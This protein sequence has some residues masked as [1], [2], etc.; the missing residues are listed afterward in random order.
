MD[1]A[2][3][4][5]GRARCDLLGAASNLWQTVGA[6]LLGSAHMLALRDR[7]EKAARQVSGDATF[8]VAFGR[9]R[10]LTLT[11]IIALALR[12]QAQPAPETARPA[13]VLT[14]REREV[15]GLVAEGMSNKD[16]AARLVISL[17]TAET[18]VENILTKLEFNSRSQIARWLAQQRPDSV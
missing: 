7:F 14:R 13:P 18:H 2:A 8:A 5:D 16:I 9:G 11:Q 3:K 17:R 15:A 1:T 6:Q 10:A 4:G 12:E